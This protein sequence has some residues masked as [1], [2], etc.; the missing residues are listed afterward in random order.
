MKA[1]FLLEH[2]HSFLSVLSLF[3]VLL[4]TLSRPSDIGVDLVVPDKGPAYRSLGARAKQ[5]DSHQQ[6]KLGKFLKVLKGES[7]L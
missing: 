6:L 4:R 3:S 2:L 5:S 7:K 1:N